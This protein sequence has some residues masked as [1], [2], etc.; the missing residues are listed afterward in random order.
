M[1]RPRKHPK[2]FG[3]DNL[4]KR[5]EKKPL[6]PSIPGSQKRKFKKHQTKKD[7]TTA[8]M[9]LPVH[10]SLPAEVSPKKRLRTTTLSLDMFDGDAAAYF[11]AVHE[12]T[13]PSLSKLERGPAGK[14]IIAAQGNIW[15]HISPIIGKKA[16]QKG[17]GP[18]ALII[19]ASADRS[20]AMTKDLRKCPGSIAKLFARHMKVTEQKT[21]LENNAIAASV[22]T[23]NRV[24]KLCDETILKLD[25][26]KVL[27]V[28]MHVDVKT[29][30]VLTHPETSSDFFRFYRDYIVALS[31]PVKIILLMPPQDA[32][33][34][35]GK[36]R[37]KST[38]IEKDANTEKLSD[39]GDGNVSEDN[40]VEDKE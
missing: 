3:N 38:G 1:E 33:S 23:P 2:K 20:C 34:A 35:K 17:H 19:S 40:H 6:R 26:L 8:S 22:G 11:E 18:T 32:S 4:R 12:A 36:P 24:L 28:D 39:Q 16:P 14:E 30:T 29:F 31:Q 10:E 5:N 25:Q 37:E 13:N 27:V 15:R 9:D 7:D 21:F